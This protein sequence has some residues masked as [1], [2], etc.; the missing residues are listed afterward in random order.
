MVAGLITGWQAGHP[1]PPPLRI[2][3]AILVA[4]GGLALADAFGRFVI[5]GMGAPARAAPTQQLV[6]GGLYRWV[7]NPM[8]LA[9]LAEI[10]GQALLLSRPVLLVYAVAVGA[11]FGAFVH[12]YEEPTLAQRYGADYEAYRRAVRGA[13]AAAAARMNGPLPGTWWIRGWVRKSRTEP[14]IDQAVCEP[15]S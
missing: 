13:A 3:G 2:A 9:V 6:I 4:A 5:E 14:R 15:I 1:Y 8:Y 10:A 12:W 11:A 7:R